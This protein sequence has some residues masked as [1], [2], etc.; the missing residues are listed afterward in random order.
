MFNAKGNHE[1]LS[2]GQIKRIKNKIAENSYEA[3]CSL[4]DYSAQEYLF[5]DD[6]MVVFK[7]GGNVDKCVDLLVEKICGDE[8]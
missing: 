3:V 6:D 2:G 8:E 4:I 7:K 5:F 1:Y